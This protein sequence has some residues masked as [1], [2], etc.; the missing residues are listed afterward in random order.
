MTSQF[1]EQDRLWRDDVATA[2]PARGMLR[3][4]R[5]F[6]VLLAFELL[7][8][9]LV[10]GMLRPDSPELIFK[11]GRNSPSPALPSALEDL[12]ALPTQID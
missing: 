6:F 3:R 2:Q 8:T 12:R 7:A 1:L 4:H 9:P 5:R 11:E 10:V